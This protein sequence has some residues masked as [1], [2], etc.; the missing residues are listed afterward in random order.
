VLDEDIAARPQ[1]RGRP[2][3]FWPMSVVTK[4]LDGLKRHLVQ[5]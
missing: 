2:P 5:K 3:N 1:Q 4:R